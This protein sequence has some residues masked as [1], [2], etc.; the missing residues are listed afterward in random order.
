[1]AKKSEYQ[2]KAEAKIL[3]LTAEADISRGLAKEARDEAA[4]HLSDAQELETQIALLKSLDAP[5]A[6]LDVPDDEP[7]D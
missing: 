6:D 7:H 4:A 3:E 2:K 1:M 5:E